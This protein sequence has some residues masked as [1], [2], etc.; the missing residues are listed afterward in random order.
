[1]RKIGIASVIVCLILAVSLLFGCGYTPK[2]LPESDINE[3]PF[4]DFNESAILYPEDIEFT[5][6]KLKEPANSIDELAFNIDVKVFESIDN[7]NEPEMYYFSL[8]DE[9]KAKVMEDA[10]VFVG[11]VL[12]I[13]PLGHNFAFS[14]D[15]S[16]LS[17]NKLGIRVGFTSDYATESYALDKVKNPVNYEFYKNSLQDKNYKKLTLSS[18]PIV[19]NNQKGYLKVYNSEQLFFAVLNEYVP[20]CETDITRKMLSKSIEILSRITNE[21]MTEAETYKAIYQYV[22]QTNVYDKETQMNINVQNRKNRAFFLEGSLLDG[23]SVCDGLT[24]EVVLLSRLMGIEAYHI[25]ARNQNNGHAYV[26]VKVNGE[27]Y[28]SCPTYG[29]KDFAVS[30]GFCQYHTQNYFLTD[31]DTNVSGWDFDSDAFEDIENLIKDTNSYDYWGQTEVETFDGIYTLHPKTIKDALIILKD[32]GTLCETSGH[33]IEVE[34]CSDVDILRNAYFEIK[35]TYPD[36]IYLSGGTY[37]GNP[38]QTY[39]FGVKR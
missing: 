39:L 21:S 20:Y 25:G 8:S 24:K 13:T 17:E 18:L 14:Y 29:L 15:V 32:A 3:F 12:Q 34:L 1:M 4:T 28:L 38:V 19:K 6:F 23:H 36:V 22:E 2:N 31:F 11:K 35:D 33:V 9:L 5:A 7:V 37:N 30:D 26:Y 16:L 27:Y 10:D